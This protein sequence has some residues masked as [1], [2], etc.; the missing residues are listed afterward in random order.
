MVVGYG[1]LETVGSALLEE[2]IG[3]AAEAPRPQQ[4]IVPPDLP[5]KRV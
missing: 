4:D 1:E 3:E 5:L 2:I